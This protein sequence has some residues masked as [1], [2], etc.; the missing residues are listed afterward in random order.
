MA[1]NE[2]LNRAQPRSSKAVLREAAKEAKVLVKR[3]AKGELSLLKEVL[4]LNYLDLKPTNPKRGEY[5]LCLN[6]THDNKGIRFLESRHVGAIIAPEKA[7]IES[8]AP[9]CI[10]EDLKIISWEG[11]FFAAPE[12]IEDVCGK[13]KEV[14]KRDLEDM[15]VDYKRGRG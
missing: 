3:V 11:L 1:E 15:L 9:A 12:D 2:S 7:R 14:K 8:L 10:L 6:T 5:I 4:S 13:R